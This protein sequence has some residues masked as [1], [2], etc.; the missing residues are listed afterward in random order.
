MMQANLEELH[1]QASGHYL[2]GEFDAA[3]VAWRSVLE[4]QPDDERARE[5]IRLCEQLAGGIDPSLVD[6][7]STSAPQA[8]PEDAILPDLDLEV[9][10]A[11]GS[12]LETQPQG[13]GDTD[14]PLLDLSQ[15]GDPPADVDQSM[16]TSAEGVAAQPAATSE[17]PALDEA[18]A[19]ELRRRVDELLSEARGLAEQSDF[20]SAQRTLDRVLILDE[21]NSSALALREAIELLVNESEAGPA[22]SAPTETEGAEISDQAEPAAEPFPPEEIST[23]D[24]SATAIPLAVES[25]ADPFATEPEDEPAETESTA[26]TVDTESA[27]VATPAKGSSLPALPLWARDRRVWFGA[28]GVLVLA[29]VFL[30]LQLFGGGDP[31]PPETVTAGMTG[32]PS[33]QPGEPPVSAEPDSLPTAESAPAVVDDLFVLLGEAEAAFEAENYAAAVIAYDQVLKHEP[34]HVEAG[35]KMK[36]AAERYREQQERQERWDNAVGAFRQGNYAEAL[37]LFYRMPQ[38]EYEADIERY[39]VNGWYNLGLS[40][41]QAKDCR[42]A[43]E[44]LEEARKV[45]PRDD[46]V[47]IAL[48]LAE[49]CRGRAVLEDVR[50]LRLRDLND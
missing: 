18:A 16:D 4:Q 45:A 47:L 3:M 17:A 26:K 20:D 13:D 14:G 46:G 42:R 25:A 1:R 40:A 30:A 24:A 7:D 33:V 23:E 29:V 2:K 27:P 38:D 50:Q 32:E 5:G 12:G 41:L 21:E 34:G 28:G 8:L 19:H 9:D 35:V 43:I 44:H 15:L 36:V 6:L 11:A 10:L 22:E 37:R 49:L 39:K 48:E 31:V